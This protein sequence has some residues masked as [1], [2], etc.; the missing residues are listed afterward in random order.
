MTDIDPKIDFTR[1]V[2]PSDDVTFGQVRNRFPILNGHEV[3]ESRQPGKYS[4]TFGEVLQGSYFGIIHSERDIARGAFEKALGQS[5]PNKSYKREEKEIKLDLVSDYVRFGI[6]DGP[7]EAKE[8]IRGIEK[9]AKN[10]AKD[11]TRRTRF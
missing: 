9:A 8:M 11:W 3:V 7:H 6:A 1:L 10:Q 4:E 5:S 2:F